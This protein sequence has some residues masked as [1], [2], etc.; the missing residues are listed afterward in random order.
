MARSHSSA[1]KFPLTTS[2]GTGRAL[3]RSEADRVGKELLGALLRNE[4]VSLPQVLTLRVLRERY[5]K[6]CVSFLD[7]SATS[8]K[9]AEGHAEVLIAFF[10]EDCDVR[11]LTEHDQLAFE[12]G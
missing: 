4:D 10:G 5:E 1:G 11:G 12:M 2:T 6:E 9:D 3:D 7:N 8:R